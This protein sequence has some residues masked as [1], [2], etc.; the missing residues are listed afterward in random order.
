MSAAAA[1]TTV[2]S[3]RM[4]KALDVRRELRVVLEEE[5]MRGVGIDLNLRVP[6]RARQQIGIPRQDHGVSLAGRQEHGQMKAAQ[7]LQSAWLVIPT[8]RPRRTVLAESPMSWSRPGH[9]S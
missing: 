2:T 9:P 4:K 6:D 8:C 5:A 7:P 1:A 3:H